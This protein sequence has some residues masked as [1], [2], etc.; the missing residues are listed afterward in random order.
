MTADT[1]DT[2]EILEEIERAATRARD[3]LALAETDSEVARGLAKAVKDVLDGW[4]YLR[5]CLEKEG[6]PLPAVWVLPAPPAPSTRPDEQLGHLRRAALA[7]GEWLETHPQLADPSLPADPASNPAVAAR[8]LAE[9]GDHLAACAAVVDD[10]CC[11]ARTTAD[12]PSDWQ[13]R[14]ELRVGDLGGVPVPGTWLTT[15]ELADPRV[16][17]N[18]GAAALAGW[19]AAAPA[20]KVLGPARVDLMGHQIRYGIVS[21]V[22]LFGTAFVRIDFPQDDEHRAP[23]FYHPGALYGLLP[24]HVEDQRD[25]NPYGEWFDDDPF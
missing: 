5:Y 2:G 4:S 23:E 3:Y 15:A 8:M 17:A 18:G 1:P 21:E 24:G 22:T 12:L 25:P 19:N 10:M 11:R 7:F 9:K 6:A 16:T 13:P 20:D 14:G